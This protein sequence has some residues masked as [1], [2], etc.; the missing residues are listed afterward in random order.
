[1]DK[2]HGT[3]SAAWAAGCLHFRAQFMQNR[4]NKRGPVIF[5][6]PKMGFGHPEPLVTHWE[7][8]KCVLLCKGKFFILEGFFLN[9]GL[10]FLAPTSALGHRI[11]QLIPF[12]LSFGELSKLKLSLLIH[13]TYWAGFSQPNCLKNS[14]SEKKNPF[15]NH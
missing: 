1:M 4:P 9:P 10:Y 13:I 6:Q 3:G 8:S 12:G 14:K 15:L 7:D 11:L 2:C 5:V